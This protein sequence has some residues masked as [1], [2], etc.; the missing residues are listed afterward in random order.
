MRGPIMELKQI[1]EVGSLIGLLAV[2]SNTAVG[3]STDV[4]QQ[5]NFV[6][7]G[8][9]QN[10]S[11]VTYVRIGN[12]DILAA[13]NA[14]G[15]YHFSSGAA[16]LFVSTDDQPPTIVVRDT[17]IGQV[18]NVDVGVYFGVSETGDAVHSTNGLTEW[19]TWAFAL[20][21]GQS[22]AKDT[23]FQLWGRTTLHTVGAGVT[24]IHG[25][26]SDVSGVG[27]LAGAVTIFYGTVQA[28]DAKAQ[29]RRS[30]H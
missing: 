29:P 14:T 18:T 28:S 16:L 9:K 15:E 2:A 8:I 3:Q 21:D 30:Q 20:S 17:N 13:L 26:Q 11:G 7:K 23:E 27:S 25:V 1:V 6:L 19:T 24:Q 10:S 4:V 22:G 5:A 12:K